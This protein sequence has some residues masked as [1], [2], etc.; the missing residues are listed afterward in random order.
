MKERLT[1]LIGTGPATARDLEL[2]GLRKVGALPAKDPEA[3]YGALRALQGGSLD[4]CVL[5]VLRCAVSWASAGEPDPSLDR[6]WSFRDGGGA[7]QP[8]KR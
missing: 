8:W 3:L 7:W 2:P 5:H 1:D 6:W 4:R